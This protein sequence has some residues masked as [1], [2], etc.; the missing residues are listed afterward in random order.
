MPQRPDNR[1]DNNGTIVQTTAN[2]FN[3]NREFEI[4]NL[5]ICKHCITSFCDICINSHSIEANLVLDAKYLG[6][7]KLYPKSVDTRVYIY[8]DRIEIPMMHLRV[9]YTFVSNIENAD[10]KRI[11]AKRIFLVGLFALGWRKKDVYTIIEYV[12][13]F[14]QKQSLV[15]DF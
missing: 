4:Y 12:Y 10:E 15:F 8:S 7:H 1:S 11:T 5:V 2:C 3:C 14:N 6:G 9:P 13:G